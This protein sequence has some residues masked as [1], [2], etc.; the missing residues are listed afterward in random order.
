MVAYLIDTV[1]PGL[2]AGPTLLGGRGAAVGRLVVVG[3][4][5]VEHVLPSC[6][7][8]IWHA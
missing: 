2:G 4:L 6:C 1:G 8:L 7:L 5:L 3:P